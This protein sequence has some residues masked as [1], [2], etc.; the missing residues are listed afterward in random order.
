MISGCSDFNVMLCCYSHTDRDMI[1]V[2]GAF[3]ESP[4]SL[5]C[6]KNPFRR[7][8]R[9]VKAFIYENHFRSMSRIRIAQ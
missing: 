2:N 6:I 4:V 9:A 1:N 5:M 7:R 8:N 3:L